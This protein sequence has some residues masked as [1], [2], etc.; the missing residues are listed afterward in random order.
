MNV[1][2]ADKIKAEI[3]A[4]EKKLEEYRSILRE[5]EGGADS[6]PDTVTLQDFLREKVTFEWMIGGLIAEGTIGMLVADPSIGKTTLLAQI[7]LLLG[8]GKEIF[9]RGVRKKYPALMIAAEGSRAAF[10]SRVDRARHSL[11]LLA[12]DATWFIQG[13]GKRREDW[14]IGSPGLERLVAESGAQFCCLDTLGYFYDGSENDA[15]EWKQGV[16][17]PLRMLAA[18]YNVTFCIVHHQVKENEFRRGWQKGRGSSAIFGDV[19]FYLRLEPVEG[20]A[21][22]AKRTLWVDKQKYG[23]AG[24]EIGLVFNKDG[25]IFEKDLG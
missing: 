16:M 15:V 23:L 9:G 17:V 20:D 24:Y 12:D 13:D 25:A 21:T 3:A 14:Q 7:T 5:L 22:G 11:G 19:D 10:R 2:I 18:K 4:E 8:T 1:T 6:G